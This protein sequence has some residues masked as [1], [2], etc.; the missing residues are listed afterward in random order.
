MTVDTR[1]TLVSCVGR[2][3]KEVSFFGSGLILIDCYCTFDCDCC[4]RLESLLLLV[5]SDSRLCLLRLDS[6]AFGN[7]IY[8]LRTVNVCMNK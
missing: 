8:L 2:G 4:V 6:L 5:G 1:Q 3:T 7:G